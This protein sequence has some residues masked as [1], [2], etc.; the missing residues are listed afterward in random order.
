M[1]NI[2][3]STALTYPTGNGDFPVLIVHGTLNYFNFREIC[4]RFV[5]IVF[6]KSQVRS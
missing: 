6:T 4:H 3:P 2:I 5:M 1:H